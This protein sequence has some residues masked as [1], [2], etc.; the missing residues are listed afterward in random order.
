[1][2]WGEVYGLICLACGVEEGP[3]AV[4]LDGHVLAVMPP[5]AEGG[6]TI[7]AVHEFSRVVAVPA[8]AVA[9]L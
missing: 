8:A 9:V 5:D 6:R 3:A 2:R 1:M 4:I 7:V